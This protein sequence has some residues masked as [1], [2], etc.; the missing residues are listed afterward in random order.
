VVREGISIG[1]DDLL[2]LANER[3]RGVQQYLLEK[4]GIAP[5]RVFV[6]SSEIVSGDKDLPGMRVDLSLGK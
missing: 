6:T 1:R 2:D 3:A 4:G 5:D